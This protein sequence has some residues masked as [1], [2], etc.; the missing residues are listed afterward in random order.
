MGHAPLPTTLRRPRGA[1]AGPATG[2]PHGGPRAA[3]RRGRRGGDRGALPAPRVRAAARGRPGHHGHLPRCRPHPGLGH[4]RAR[5]GGGDGPPRRLVF[6]GDLGRPG[7]PIIR[8]PTTIDDGADYVIMES[9]YGGREHEPADEAIR[10]LAEIVRET[11][12]HRGVL[13]IPA[14]AIGRTQEIVWHLDRLLSAGQIPHLPL[15]LDSPMASLASD[16][17][18]RYPGYYDEETFAPAGGRRDAARL[19]GRAGHHEPGD[20]ARHRAG[21]AADDHRGLERHAHRRPRRLPPAGAHRRPGRAAALRGLPGGGHAGRPPPGRRATRPPRRRRSARCA[22]GC[23]PS[24]ASRPT[25]TSRSCSTGWATSR[26]AIAS[27]GPCSSSTATPRPSTR[28]SRRCEAMGLSP[29][30]PAWREEVELA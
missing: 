7:T 24:A 11:A 27:R 3:L 21:A 29:Y 19:P 13:L 28:W 23:G 8:D 26:R 25:R 15:Y 10:L 17:Y 2:H 4:H 16:I 18:H 30:R 1:A 14:F 20:L 22:A 6:S 12:S 9:T 5:R